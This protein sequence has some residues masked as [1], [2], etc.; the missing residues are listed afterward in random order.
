MVIKVPGS[1]RYRTT[2][3]P[4]PPS[5]PLADVLFPA[6]PPP[7]PVFAMPFLLPAVTPNGDAPP[8]PL[9]GKPTACPVPL[10]RL[11]PA[12][13]PA[14][15]PA[16][17][18]VVPKNALASNPAPPFPPLLSVPAC[19]AWLNPPPPPPAWPAEPGGSLNHP[20]TRHPIGLSVPC[21]GSV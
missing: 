10:V 13:P 21:K 4:L 14:N 12:P 19:P 16:S 6:P 5:P 18:I 8:P 15:Q 2:T 20:L 11:L 17:P 9:P 7:P 1:T 3:I